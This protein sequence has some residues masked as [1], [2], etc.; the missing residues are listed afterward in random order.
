MTPDLCSGAPRLRRIDAVAAVL[1]LLLLVLYLAEGYLAE[2]Y[3]AG[4]PGWLDAAKLGTADLCCLVCFGAAV[5][6]RKSVG[7]RRARGRRSEPQQ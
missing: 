2:G 5:A 6:T 7:P 3:L 1:W 4:A